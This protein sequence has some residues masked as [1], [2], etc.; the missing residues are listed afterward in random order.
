[1]IMCD[2]RFL[3]MMERVTTTDCFLRKRRGR[4]MI[5]MY[6]EQHFGPIDLLIRLGIKLVDY[7]DKIDLI[8]RLITK[9]Y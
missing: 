1:M 4:T 3:P 2:F 8:R 9:Y 5:T 7:P 6:E